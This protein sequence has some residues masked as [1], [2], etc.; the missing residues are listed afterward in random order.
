MQ[1]TLFILLLTKNQ[2]DE[3]KKIS[4]KALPNEAVALG[5]GV[6][7]K[8]DNLE[9]NNLKTQFLYYIIK[10]IEEFQSSHPSPIYFLLDDVELLYKKWMNAQKKGLK[11][12]C[13]FHSHPSGCVPSG[14]DKDYMKNIS[15]VYPFIIWLIYGNTSDKFQAY[16]YNNNKI[17]EVKMIIKND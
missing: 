14:V 17:S 1:H 16:L 5:F 3:L 12:I 4:I 8:K 7:E 11:L 10:I 6:I 13:I 15:I 2:I 9:L